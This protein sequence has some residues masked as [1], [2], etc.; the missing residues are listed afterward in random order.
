MPQIYYLNVKI[1]DPCFDSDLTLPA[2]ESI[3][4]SP[5]STFSYS[6]NLDT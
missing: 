3:T 2:V 4:N 5:N 6:I 1:T